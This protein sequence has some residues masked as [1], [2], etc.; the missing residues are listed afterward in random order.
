MKKLLLFLLIFALFL[1]GCSAP[2]PVEGEKETP[3]VP[4]TEEQT[5][6][7]DDDTPKLPASTIIY[8]E[9]QPERKPPAVPI[10]NKNDP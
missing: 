4:P 9:P 2:A 8:P 5:P 10:T 1:T 6:T 3:D 7:P